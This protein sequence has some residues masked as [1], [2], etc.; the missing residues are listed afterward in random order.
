MQTLAQTQKMD[1]LEQEVHELREEVTTLR[2]EVERLANLVSSLKITQD[3]P[4]VQRNPNLCA[5]NHLKNNDSHCA[6]NCLNNR[7]LN[8]ST[9][10]IML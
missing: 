2:A 10:G 1:K 7:L 8:R 9:H 4:L 6:F 5:Y 3:Q